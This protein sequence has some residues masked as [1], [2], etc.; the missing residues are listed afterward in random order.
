MDKLS[1]PPQDLA[2]LVLGYL[3][4]EELMTAY[5]EFLQASPY[6]DAYENEYDRILMTSLRSIL[7]DYRAVKIYV[8]SCKP[9][10]LRKKLLQCYNL[11]EMVKYL[12]TVVD[13]QKL[14]VQ[15]NIDRSSFSKSMALPRLSCNVCIAMN[16]KSC[17][18]KNKCMTTEEKQLSAAE[19]NLHSSLEATPLADL[20][21]NVLSSK[22][23]VPEKETKKITNLEQTNFNLTCNSLTNITEPINENLNVHLNQ[24]NQPPKVVSDSRQKIEEFNTILNL[25]CNKNVTNEKLCDNLVSNRGSNVSTIH[26]FISGVQGSN[27]DKEMRVPDSSTTDPVYIPIEPK[28]SETIITVHTKYTPKIVTDTQKRNK[29]D[30]NV[31][32]LSDVKFDNPY[33]FGSAPAVL[34]ATSTPNVTNTKRL[35]INGTPGFTQKG[36]VKKCNFSKDEIMAMPTLIILP[37]SGS[38]QN[39][40]NEPKVD[41]NKSTTTTSATLSKCEPLFVDVSSS[42]PS[43]AITDDPIDTDNVM[44]HTKNFNEIGLIKTVDPVTHASLPKDNTLSTKS[45]TPHVLPPI[46]KSSS[47]P[48]RTSHIRV[49]DFNTPRRILDKALSEKGSNDDDA[50]VII[51]DSPLAPQFSDVEKPPKLDNV[52]KNL[53]VEMNKVRKPNWDEELRALVATNQDLFPPSSLKT[54]KKSKRKKKKTDAENS[55]VKSSSVKSKKSKKKKDTKAIEEPQT[56]KQLPIKPTIKIVAAVEPGSHSEPDNDQCINKDIGENF[57]TPE[58]ERLSLQN[59]IGVKLNISDLLET[60]Y[61]Q[62][63]YDIQMDTPKFLGP[64]LPGEPISD[65]KIMNIPTPRLFDN[66]NPAEATPSSYSS[67]PTDYSSGGSYYKPDEQDYPILDISEHKIEEPPK[68]QEFKTTDPKKETSEIKTTTKSRRPTRKCTKNVSYYNSPNFRVNSKIFKVASRDVST[69]EVKTSSVPSPDL[70]DMKKKGRPFKN[71]ATKPDKHKSPFKRDVTKNFMK[72]KPRRVTP[73]KDTKNRRSLSDIALSAKKRN[74]MKEKHSKSSPMVVAPSKSRRKSSTPRKLQ[75]GKVFHSS[76]SSNTSPDI[77]GSTTIKNINICVTRDNSVEQNLLRWYDDAT[78]NDKEV[79][80]SKTS[81]KGEEDSKIKIKEHIESINTKNNTKSESNPSTRNFHN[82]LVKRGLDVETAR[83]IERDLMDLDGPPLQDGAVQSTS[84]ENVEENDGKCPPDRVK[85][86]L[87]V[88]KQNVDP[89]AKITHTTLPESDEEI[90][91]IEFSV[92]ESNEESSNYFVHKFD[93]A[94]FTPKDIAHLKDKFCMEVCIDDGVIL[95]L[96]AT[97]FTDLVNEEPTNKAYDKNEI[98][99]AV[100]SIS[101]IEKLYTP[102]K[103]RRA[104][105][106]ELFDSTLTSI[107]TPLKA[108]SPKKQEHDDSITEIIVDEEIVNTKKRKRVQ[109]QEDSVNMKKSKSDSQYLLNHA[110]IQNIDIESVLSKLHGP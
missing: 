49:L 22:K 90:E 26:D 71:K 99:S 109:S 89:I 31:K 85:G 11:L 39:F 92:S 43:L 76:T 65:I 10:P 97:N 33:A 86:G 69:E 62:A 25:V 72:I 34:K 38:T 57:D 66:P 68:T 44:T 53:N 58:N 56:K 63:I 60:P 96:K 40:V 54:D 28:P 108:N 75:C 55:D 98:D 14:P 8:E 84:N 106:Y 36:A 107:D 87:Y 1:F 29:P 88:N 23:V 4:E 93:E 37:T 83:I 77:P 95:R 7:A 103:D 105:C 51:S 50:V 27:H 82:D 48:R 102:M 6:L 3:A 101:N 91:D 104:Q 67:R 64:D 41:T 21:G 19:F 12:I 2:K 16:S 52:V 100:T 17:V 46:R 42:M 32:I 74:L 35:M 61:K 81:T 47:T 18:C 73:I 70:N 9:P 59:E 13:L 94:S 80:N 79:Q 30:S 45:S 110:S 15:E 78:K 5:D 24:N 20:P